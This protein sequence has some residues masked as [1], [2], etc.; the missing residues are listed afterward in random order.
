LNF[1]LKSKKFIKSKQKK[2]VIWSKNGDI[3]TLGSI[4]INSD[5]RL[6]VQ[7]RYMSEWHLKIDNVATDDEGEYICKT[8]GKF[9]KVI[10]LQ[11]LMPPTI[12]DS[13]ST[14]AGTVTLKEG[15]SITLK[16]FADGKPEPAL[17]WYRWKKYKHLISDKEELDITGNEVVL[18]AV[19]RNDPN[20][21]ECIAKN[22][23]P[24]ATSRIFTIEIHFLPVIEL[25]VRKT[26]QFVNK[27][28]SLECK[29]SAN[30]L[31]RVYWIK[32]GLIL[33]ENTHHQMTSRDNSPSTRIDN[34]RVEKYD[35]SNMNDYFKVLL[36]LTI[37]VSV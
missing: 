15:S 27:K 16:C 33:N 34:Y 2:K 35:V 6:N 11:V 12:D 24:P 14:A 19:R 9:F 4:K 36:T 30:P 28:F 18:P 32:N 23:V 10:N 22:S 13:R 26:F 7:H 25:E 37:L 20:V 29:I 1:I 5:P 3:L 21:Y 31:E 8:N 17:R